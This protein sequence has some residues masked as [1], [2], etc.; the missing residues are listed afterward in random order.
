[1]TLVVARIVEDN[2]FIESDSKI[3]DERLVKNNPLCGLLKTF[4]LHPFVSIS[5]AGNIVFA[6]LALKKVFEQKIEDVNVLLTMLSDINIESRNTTDFIVAT[7]I[8]KIPKLYKVADGNVESNILNAWIGDVDGFQ[9]YQKEYH[10]TQEHSEIKERM[11]SAFRAVIEN[12][13]LETIGDFHISTSL[14]YEINP[15][16]PVFL[17][18]FKVNIDVTE[19]QLIKIEEKGKF[20]SVPLG[21]REG[22]SHGLSYLATASPDFHGVAIH[23]THGNFG[24]L[25]CPQLSFNGILLK[26]INGR[27]FVD[28]IKT[29]YDIPLR[30]FIK[31][32]DSA[33]QYIDNRVFSDL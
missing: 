6:E 7:I 24:L 18:D 32:N 5:F 1:M 2:I 33:I 3:T 12:S 22:G 26:D 30:G 21:T 28:K 13:E 16:H 27:D 15:N 8:G 4:I 10:S 25:F 9:V 14:N 23:F 19:P 11:K 31:M 29:D 20:E 17:H